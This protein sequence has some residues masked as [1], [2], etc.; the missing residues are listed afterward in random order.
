MQKNVPKYTP[1]WVRDRALWAETSQARRGATRCATTGA[2][3]CGSPTSGRSSTTRRWSAPSRPDRPT[4]LVLDLDPPEGDALPDGGPAS[5]TSS[6]RRSTDARPARARS[7]RAARRACTCSCRST[8][9]PLEEAAAAT[10]AIAAR[11][12]RLDPDARD[13][14]VH[15]GGPRRQ[16]V[17]RLH[18]RRR[19]DGGRGLQP[20]GPAGRAG[21]VPGGVGRP[22]R[23]RPGRLHHPHRARTARRRRPVG[24][25]RCPRRSRCPRT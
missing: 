9:A 22:R 8:T 23:R 13:D 6:A 4:H 5:R 19:R 2:R 17:R 7:R 12:E 25:A 16:G 21:V 10:R 1:D 3:C 15:E 20:P 24:R 18:P 14:G 11:A